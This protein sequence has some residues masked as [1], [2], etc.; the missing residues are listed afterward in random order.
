MEI[1][2][3]DLLIEIRQQNKDILERL[4]TGEG[5]FKA[6]DV[7]LDGH[8]DRISATEHRLRDLDGGDGWPSWV[9]LQKA[10]L[11]Q[12]TLV[13]AAGIIWGTITA[14]AVAL[15]SWLGLFSWHPPKP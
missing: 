11:R 7:R 9:D 12:R 14:G 15:T 5:M 10:H 2:E 4:K 13:W 6:L 8:H 3:R 1:T